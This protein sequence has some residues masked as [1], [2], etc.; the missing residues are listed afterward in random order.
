MEDHAAASHEGGRSRRTKKYPGAHGPGPAGHARACIRAC[1]RGK[2]NLNTKRVIPE[3]R[4]V[5]LAV[6]KQLGDQTPLNVLKA[7]GEK[8]NKG[9]LKHP[10]IFR[11]LPTLLK[12]LVLEADWKEVPYDLDLPEASGA[13]E[14]G[15]NKSVQ[16]QKKLMQSTLLYETVRPI[17]GMYCANETLVNAVSWPFVFTAGERR[18]ITTHRRALVAA[19]STAAAPSA[20]PIFKVA[21]T[22]AFTS[23]AKAN[24]SSSTPA[25]AAAG[26]SNLPASD[27]D[28]E[29]YTRRHQ[30]WHKR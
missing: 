14:E 24:Q 5:L 15:T 25:P 13:S 26:A 6:L 27:I 20:V 18:M 21:R 12:R 19:G 22:F 16:K 2:E 7:L 11:P 4:P 10:D 9:S 8:G 30:S 28:F 29:A 23:P 3:L 1:C 17:L